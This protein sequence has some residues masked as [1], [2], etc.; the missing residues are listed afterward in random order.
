M[1]SRTL[2][3]APIIGKVPIK[4]L[5][6]QM[7]RS[8]VTGLERYRKA[9][10][11]RKTDI[12]RQKG[13]PDHHLR[14]LNDEKSTTQMFFKRIRQP[15][16]EFKILPERGIL[17]GKRLRA[18]GESVVDLNKKGEV[19]ACIRK[20][21]NF[22]EIDFIL[23]RRTAFT[24]KRVDAPHS[25]QYLIRIPEGP[26]REILCTMQAIAFHDSISYYNTIKP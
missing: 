11:L 9:V 24:L 15:Y 10:R 5:I 19:A 7:R 20:R 6:H 18:G 16:H 14:V 21:D 3:F 12:M 17:Y 4:S 22:E 25:R 26:E 2:R 1:L 23:P 8:E 13:M